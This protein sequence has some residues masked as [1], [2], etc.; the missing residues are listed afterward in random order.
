MIMI[1]LYEKEKKSIYIQPG[2]EHEYGN[3]L[4]NYEV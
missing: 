4:K 2:Y 1:L 3:N